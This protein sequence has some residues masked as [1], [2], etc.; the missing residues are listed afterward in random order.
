VVFKA[1]TN[2]LKMFKFFCERNSFSKI[3]TYADLR[4]SN[5]NVY[6]WLDFCVVSQT[7]P[8]YFYIIDGVRKHRFSYRKSELKNKLDVFDNN[9]TEY[10]NMLLNRYDRIWDCG[11][12]KLEHNSTV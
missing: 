6:K 11:H 2:Y 4:F 5:G 3:V 1:T 7:P 12:L 10:E 9:K 8:N